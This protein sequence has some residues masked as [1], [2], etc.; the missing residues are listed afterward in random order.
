[1]DG[2]RFR[3]F[4]SGWTEPWIFAGAA[5]TRA[6]LAGAGFTDIDVSLEPAPTTLAN[7]EAYKDFIACVCVRHH[8][9]GLPPLERAEFLE[10]LASGAGNDDPAFTLDYWRLNIDACKPLA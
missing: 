9:D 2:T 3:Q 7:A 10:A 1:M 5:E 4:F 6:R 8:V